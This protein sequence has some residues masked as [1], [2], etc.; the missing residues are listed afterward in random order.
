MRLCSVYNLGLIDYDR[1]LELQERLHKSRKSGAISDVLLLLQHP[2]VFTIG[3]SGTANDIIASEE[4]LDREN[5]QVFRTSRGGEV[6][7]HGPG[8]LVGYPILHLRE[9]KLTVHQYVWN[10][11]EMVMR[12]LTDFGID[13]QRVS[14]RRGVWVGGEKICSLGLRISSEVSMHG[15]SLNVNTDLKHFTYIVPC[16]I[17]DATITSLSKLLGYE[18]K[19]EEVEEKLL[20]RFSEVFNLQLQRGERLACV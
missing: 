8:Q 19:M 12:T 6:T 20:Q 5:I 18:V 11:E 9:D 7:Y 16:G 10:L 14:G 15:F 1:A 2:S 17:T 4:L 13:S 3:R